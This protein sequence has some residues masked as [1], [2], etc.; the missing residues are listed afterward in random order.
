MG[1]MT[2]AGWA[3]LA[4]LAGGVVFWSNVA[5]AAGAGRG[6]IEALGLSYGQVRLLIGGL[7][8]FWVGLSV[9]CVLFVA[10]LERKERRERRAWP[11]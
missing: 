2:C 6:G 5:I 8:G 9:G 11:S 3:A 1:R 7:M 4:I 10:Y